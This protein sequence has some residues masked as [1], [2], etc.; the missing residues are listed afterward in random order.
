MKCL[1]EW[2][3]EVIWWADTLKEAYMDEKAPMMITDQGWIACCTLPRLTLFVL[4]PM[5]VKTMTPAVSRKGSFL[6]YPLSFKIL[7]LNC[8]NDHA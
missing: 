4:H 1:A 6:F 3:H 8:L 5:V 2:P 7:E